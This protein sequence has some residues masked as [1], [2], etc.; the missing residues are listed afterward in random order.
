MEMGATLEDVALT[1]HAH[2][3]FSEAIM[4]AAEHAHGQAIH[5]S[6]RRR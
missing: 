2:P 6:N 4:E 3:T 5:R 1:Q